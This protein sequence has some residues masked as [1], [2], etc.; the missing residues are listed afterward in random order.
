MIEQMTYQTP[1][2]GGACEVEDVTYEVYAEIM[3]PGGVAKSA[4]G[5]GGLLVSIA[6]SSSVIDCGEDVMRIATPGAELVR[7]GFASGS[8]SVTMRV[9]ASIIGGHRPSLRVAAL[10]DANDNGSCDQGELTASID[11]HAAELGELLLELTDEG[12]PGR[13]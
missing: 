7:E 8:E 11:A 6:E 13:E 2:T 3:R 5:S 12:C 4:A 1:V 10:L 9:P